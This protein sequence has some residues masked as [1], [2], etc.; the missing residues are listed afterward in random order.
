MLLGSIRFHEYKPYNRFC[1]SLLSACNTGLGLGLPYE[2]V[3]I[4]QIFAIDILQ[5]LGGQFQVVKLSSWQPYSSL[6]CGGIGIS[7]V[8]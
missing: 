8:D 7:L 6:R 3:P 1:S 2:A 4:K 5:S